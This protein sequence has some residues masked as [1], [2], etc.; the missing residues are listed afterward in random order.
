MILKKI[1]GYN[2][3]LALIDFYFQAQAPTQAPVEEDA[4][5][6][7][8]ALLKQDAPPLS[9]SYTSKPIQGQSHGE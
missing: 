8:P 2:A 4:P 3:Q 5:T 1:S 9:S 6:Q 7:A